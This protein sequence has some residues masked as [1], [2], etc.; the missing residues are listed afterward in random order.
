MGQPSF[1]YARFSYVA[2][3][4]RPLGFI[5]EK[6]V[7]H[8]LKKIKPYACSI[9]V[10]CVGNI[11]VGGTGKTPVCLALADYF[12]RQNKNAVFLNHGYKSV[13]QNIL[14]DQRVHTFEEV[15]D[16]ALIFASK[17]P[18]VVDRN[19][20]RG[21]QKIESIGADVIIMDDGF[22]NPTLRKDLSLVVFDGARGIGNGYVMPAGPLRESLKQGLKRASAAV[23]VGDDKTG[24]VAQIRQAYPKLPILTGHIEAS[25]AL[26]GITG[27]AFAGI[28]FPKKFFSML[29]S[30]GVHL[31]ETISFPDHYAYTRKDIEA[32]LQKGYPVLTT[33]KDAVKIDEDLRSELTIVDIDFVFDN[34]EKLDLLLERK[35]K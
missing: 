9:P 11:S 8:R 12:I 27:V 13:L 32:I 10:I 23:I 34:P 22:Q 26:R 2:Q 4:L 25:Q 5:Y 21:A 1:W 15:S 7:A 29:Q 20:A 17:L 16:E 3:V 18:T 33:M 19:R 30:I 35:L 14:I 6:I 24:L 28:G 31:I